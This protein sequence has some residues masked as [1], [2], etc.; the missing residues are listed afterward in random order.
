MEHSSLIKNIV[1]HLKQVRGVHALV[2][3]GSYAS[4]TQHPDSDIDI[5]IYYREEQPLDTTQIRTVATLLND[6]PDPVVT[7]I[8]GWGR[9]VNGGSWLTIQG[10]RVDFL[11]RNSN[12]VARTLNNCNNGIFEIDYSQ[13]PPYGFYSYMYCAETQICQPLYDPNDVIPQLKAKVVTYPQPLKQAILKHNLW[14][15]NFSLENGYKTAKRGDVYF[16]A[17][18]V[19]R[20]MSMLVQVLYTLN[21]TYFLSE[22]NLAKNIHD[23]KKVPDDFVQ[24]VE[25]ILSNLGGDAEQLTASID[26]TKEL[27]QDLQ[28]LVR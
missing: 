18:C 2:L 16:T 25:D 1:T 5:A 6:T 17:G 3:G 12:F 20:A 24:R 13:Q 15:A 7:D 27:L 11:Y 14:S 10:Q 26:S 28:L 21:E 9:W 19:A 8:G 22:K 4:G 23:F